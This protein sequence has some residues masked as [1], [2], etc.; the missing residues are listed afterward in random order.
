MT[1]EQLKN[2]KLI[3]K[4]PFLKFDY[5]YENEKD[6]DATIL[7][8]MTEGWI[9]AFG[10]EMCEELKQALIEETSAYTE[11][12][13]KEM[14]EWY[15]N[16]KD[17]KI[18]YPLSLLYI[19]KIEQLKE[20]YGEMRLY[21]NFYT[22]KIEDIIEKYTIISQTTCINCG[23][24]AKWLSTGWICPF[25]DDCKVDDLIYTPIVER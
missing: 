5:K 19:W 8:C 2:K 12:E 3:E 21:P 15:V 10:E 6:Y 17:S 24:K 23:K 7:D 9:T 4:Y 25:C 11:E 1:E 20:K 22:E 13:L 18:K 16:D 14:Y